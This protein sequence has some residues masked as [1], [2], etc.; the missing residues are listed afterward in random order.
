MTSSKGVTVWSAE[1][2]LV[3]LISARTL[4]LVLYV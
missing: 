1:L 4:T 3:H 2:E